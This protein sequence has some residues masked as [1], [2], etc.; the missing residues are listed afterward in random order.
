M[1]YSLLP[2]YKAVAM[3]NCIDGLKAVARK[4]LHKLLEE[5][6]KNTQDNAVF[7]DD[8]LSFDASRISNIF[9]DID[10]SPT[11]RM[12]YDIEG[13]NKEEKPRAIEEYRFEKDKTLRFLLD[14]SQKD[15]IRRSLALYGKD[16]LG[17]ARALTKLHMKRLLRK[18]DFSLEGVGRN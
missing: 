14:D 2:V 6:N 8:A 4:T 18:P 9:H 5:H 7:I 15:I 17:V 12:T 16:R 13:F 11:E 1:G 3:T 10:S